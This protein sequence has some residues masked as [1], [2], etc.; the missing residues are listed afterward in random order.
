[1]RLP[2]ADASADVVCAGEIL[3]HVSDL[4]LAV[5]ESCRVLRP[6]GV[7]ILDTIANTALARFLAITVAERIPGLAPPRIHDPRLF[8]DRRKLVAAYA[9]F[10]VR[11]R[12]SGLRPSIPDMIG[13]LAKRRPG[14]RLVDTASTA[15]LFQAWGTKDVS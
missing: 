8:V 9:S 2:F 10:G 1:M 3:E 11:L 14:V 6:G 12:L 15:V 4:A 5:S 13:W 7:L